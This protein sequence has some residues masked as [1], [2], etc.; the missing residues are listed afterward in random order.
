M[1]WKRGDTFLMG[2]DA[3]HDETLMHLHI[4]LTDPDPQSGRVVVVIVPIGTYRGLR[5]HEDTC[6]LTENDGHS[7]I[8]RRSYV[9]YQ[10]AKVV[11]IAILETRTIRRKE[12]VSEDVLSKIY[13]GACK[14]RKITPQV[15]NFLE[16]RGLIL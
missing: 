9:A 1:P 12:R 10:W 5:E 8:T 16:K 14:S 6:I 7:F 3:A 13:A 15:L 2:G 11:D 4:V